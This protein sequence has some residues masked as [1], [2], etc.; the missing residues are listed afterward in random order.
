M[1]GKQ[2]LYAVVVKYFSSYNQLEKIIYRSEIP[3]YPPAQNDNFWIQTN[4][5]AFLNRFYKIKE[6][7]EYVKE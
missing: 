3:K 7:E 2:L 5:I 4:I 1:Y 6:G